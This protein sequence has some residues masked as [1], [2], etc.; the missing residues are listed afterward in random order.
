MADTHGLT[1]KQFRFCEEYLVDCNAS[2]AARVA[3][4]SVKTAGKIATE[5]LQ[6]PAIKAYIQERL[7]AINDAK[8]AKADEVLRYLTSV[9]RGE[10][11]SE[12]VIVEGTGEGKSKARRVEKLP[13]EK[14][15]TKAAELLGKRMALWDGSGKQ[16]KS[17]G[18]LESLLALV[19]KQNSDEN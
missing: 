4:Y 6:K 7:E 14:E 9:M 19:E 18:I 12:V 16:T 2:R 17:N 10:S 8:I 11:V 1:Q 13:D 3:G 5:Y 15:R